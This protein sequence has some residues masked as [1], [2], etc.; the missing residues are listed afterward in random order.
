MTHHSRE[1]RMP[2]MPV[3]RTV[4]NLRSFGWQPHCRGRYQTPMAALP[5]ICW[6]PSA[7]TRNETI[8]VGV[9]HRVFR[10]SSRFTASVSIRHP[11]LQEI[12]HFEPF[13]GHGTHCR[14]GCHSRFA[15]WGP[16]EAEGA[17]S[18]MK[19]FAGGRETPPLQR[20]PSM[21]LHEVTASPM[22]GSI[23]PLLD[24]PRAAHLLGVSPKTLRDWIQARRI[25][26]VKVGTRVMLRA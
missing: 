21:A 4:A 24:V 19:H 11:H 2:D 6:S 26:Y 3:S 16:K 9:L 22:P 18:K 8:R 17:H 12:F 14:F 15:V 10:E 1:G 7:K 20:R 25:E 5:A 13:E 23:E